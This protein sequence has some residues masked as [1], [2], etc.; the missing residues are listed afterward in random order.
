MYYTVVDV[1]VLTWNASQIPWCHDSMCP[2]F[3]HQP[4]MQMR[5]TGI[6][7][8]WDLLEGSE[9]SK[10]WLG[11]G[12]WK[13]LTPPAIHKL[14]LTES[15]RHVVEPHYKVQ[16]DC[17]WNLWK[18]ILIYSILISGALR[19]FVTETKCWLT[20]P[21]TVTSHPHSTQ[22]FTAKHMH[23]HSGLS[24]SKHT[25][26]Y[27]NK[28]EICKVTHTFLLPF[29]PEHRMIHQMVTIVFF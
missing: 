26:V 22:N 2:R 23:T 16:R 13:R 7:G 3:G 24:A 18:T 20:Q 19:C 9:V 8:R 14:S 15:L 4:A 10:P 11:T 27:Q 17:S 12:Y 5:G 1:T 21:S 29:R 6:H 28:A 25:T